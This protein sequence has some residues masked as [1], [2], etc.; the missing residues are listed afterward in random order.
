MSTSNSNF[1]R[2][3]RDQVN[4]S[5]IIVNLGSLVSGLGGISRCLTFDLTAESN[6]NPTGQKDHLGSFILRLRFESC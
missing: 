3:V 1:A 6:I 5:L 4:F 2:T